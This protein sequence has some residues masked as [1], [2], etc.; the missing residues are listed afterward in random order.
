VLEISSTY[1]RVKL[2][3]GER[4]RRDFVDVLRQL[5]EPLGF[6]LSGWVLMPEHFHLLLP[7]Q[8][9]ESTSRILPELKKQTA[10]R[11]ISRLG[12][13]RQYPWCGKVLGGS[14]CRPAS[15]ALHTIGSAAALLSVRRLQREGTTGE[16]EL[17]SRQRDEEWREPVVYAHHLS[18]VTRHCSCGRGKWYWLVTCSRSAGSLATAFLAVVELL[19]LLP[20]GFYPLA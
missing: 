6:L 1:R 4:L 16:A 11:V 18:L 15:T 5:R 20:S 2:F 17:R 14:A 7:P 3:E 12:A 9:A 8:S 13:N 10:L 19:V